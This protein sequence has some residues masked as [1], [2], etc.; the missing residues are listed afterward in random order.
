MP[1]DEYILKP[2]CCKNKNPMDSDTVGA[3][4]YGFRCSIPTLSFASII[5]SCK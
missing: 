5:I 1:R 2:I 3:F 4:F